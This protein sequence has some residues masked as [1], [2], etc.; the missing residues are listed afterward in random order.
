MPSDPIMVHF[1]ACFT[2]NIIMYTLEL[3]IGE[4]SIQ[5]NTGSLQMIQLNSMGILS[6]N[7]C[8]L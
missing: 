4:E 5:H 7:L 2:C 3:I 8:N 1:A 6:V